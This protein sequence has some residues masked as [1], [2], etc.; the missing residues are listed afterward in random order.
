MIEKKPAKIRHLVNW[1]YGNFCTRKCYERL[2]LQRMHYPK[3]QE[4]AN[5]L[6]GIEM[7]H[8]DFLNMLRN[9]RTICTLSDEEWKNSKFSWKHNGCDICKALG[10]K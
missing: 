1:Y 4:L 2:D 8:K 10:I 6:E 7:T 5:K 3:L 9:D